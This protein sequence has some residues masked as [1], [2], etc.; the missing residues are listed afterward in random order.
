MA[1]TI[2]QRR[3]DLVKQ[4]HGKTEEERDAIRNVRRHA[5]D[6]LRKLLKDGVS[7]DEERRAEDEIEKL[8]SRHVERVEAMDKR[9]ERELLEV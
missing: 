8:T 2:K 6:E 7:E 5:I 3:K 1:V 9:K 4:V